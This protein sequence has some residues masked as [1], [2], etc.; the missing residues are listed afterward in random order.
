MLPDKFKMRT[1][2]AESGCWNWN[3][4]VD[5]YGYGKC[6]GKKAHRV[7]YEI[8]VGPIPEG[9]T[10]DHI[11]WNK[12]CVNPAHL[13]VLGHLDNA[14]RQRSAQATHCKNSHEFTPENTYWRTENC[15]GQRQCRTCNRMA[16]RR[17][18]NRRNA[19]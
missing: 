5:R 19:A 7:A 1:T 9:L 11:C 10:I 14:S 8:F 18:K 4:S 3:L 16:A 6:S 12:I 15:T 17:Y 2:V 13:R